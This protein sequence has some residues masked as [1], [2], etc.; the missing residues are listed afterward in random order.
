MTQTVGCAISLK[1]GFR[2][3]TEAE[4]EYAARGGQQKPYFNFPWGD[5]ADSTMANW[6]ESRNPY[7]TGPLPWT[8]PAG[9]FNGKLHNKADFG[10]PSSQETFQTANGANGYGLYDMGGQR[11]AVYQWTGMA[12][13]TT[14]KGPIINPTGPAKGSPMPD[15][16]AYRGMRGGN[17]FNG[18]NGHSRVS[19][20]NPS[21]YRGPLDPEHP[22][23]HIGFR[24]VLPVDAEN[25]VAGKRVSEQRDLTSENRFST[26]GWPAWQRS[27]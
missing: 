1:S 5:K 22:Y 16:K 11:L 27:D 7:R 14:P 18:E 26:F 17:W 12:A 6:P 2:L 3:P 19:N 9:F 20:R 4:W 10:W 15:G 24:V 8:T 21:Y 13:I 25:R 23:Y